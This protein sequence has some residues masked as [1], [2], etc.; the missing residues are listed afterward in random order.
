MY[1]KDSLRERAMIELW[2][3][4]MKRS[5]KDR[6]KGSFHELK[7][8]VKEKVGKTT[9]NPRLQA[10][11]IGEKLAGKI[12]KKIGQVEEAIENRKR[13]GLRKT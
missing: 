5:T 10:E 13:V 3:E 7:G 11:G 9:N 4:T 8:K 1:G 12:Q 2:E 6:A